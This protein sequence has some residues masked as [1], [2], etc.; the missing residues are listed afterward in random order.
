MLWIT[1]LRR[2]AVRDARGGRSQRASVNTPIL[3]NR[4]RRRRR[5]SSPAMPSSSAEGARRGTGRAAG[6]RPRGRCAPHPPA[7]ARSRRSTPS[8]RQWRASGRSA[9]AAFG[10]SL[11]VAPQDGRAA[12]GRDDR[13]ERV[14]LHEHPVGER[15]RDGAAR[16]ALA[17]HAA[18]DRDR[19]ARHHRLRAPRSRRPAR[20]AR[21]R[22]PGRRPACRRA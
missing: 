9:A 11:R 17:D 20:A 18:D 21:R 12:L 10:A 16:P 13:V 22:R 8:S 1:R 3:R 2:R 6:P 4:S 14:L 5:N 15:D 19:Q 7:R